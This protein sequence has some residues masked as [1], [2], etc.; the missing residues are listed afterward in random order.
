MRLERFCYARV[1]RVAM[2]CLIY[3]TANGSTPIQA[4]SRRIVTEIA[5]SPLLHWPPLVFFCAVIHFRNQRANFD[6]VQKQ[7][8]INVSSRDRHHRYLNSI[9]VRPIFLVSLT[10]L[11][12]L[13]QQS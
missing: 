13:P 9:S 2:T 7:V 1:Q 3:T 6:V 5:F 8:A 4:N 11:I 10:S 12:S